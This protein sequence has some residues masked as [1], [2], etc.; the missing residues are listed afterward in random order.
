MAKKHPG[1]P[2]ALTI[3]GSDSGGGAGIQADLRTFSAFDVHGV[4]AITAVTAQNTAS[5]SAIHMLPTRMIDAQ[6]DAV[7]DDFTIGAVKTGMLGT[8]AVVRRVRACLDRHPDLFLIVDP[9]LV[10]TSGAQL[11]EAGLVPAMHR[12]LLARADVLTPNV[13]EAERLLDRT[14]RSTADLLDAARRLQDA[15]ARTVLLKGG[16]LE[17]RMVKDVLVTPHGTSTFTHRRINL[18]GHGTGCTLS[19]AIAAGMANGRA[20]EDAVAEA[21]EFVHRALAQAFRPGRGDMAL[22]DHLAAR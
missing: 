19:A 3:A 20:L 18:E 1:K 16:H 4:C 5:V 12:H 15:G 11:A 7:F 6:L 2:V 9:V 22:L 21:I 17:G 10:A 13:P 8:P 14:I